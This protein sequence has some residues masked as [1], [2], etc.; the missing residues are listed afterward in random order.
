MDIASHQSQSDS[1]LY[2]GTIQVYYYVW[3]LTSCF[4]FL[5]I[6]RCRVIYF[7]HRASEFYFWFFPKLYYA[8]AET[9]P[10]KEKAPQSMQGFQLVSFRCINIQLYMPR[11]WYR[12]QG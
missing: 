1:A 7:T 5:L 3:L 11:N 10:G 6:N 8:F 4:Y 2:C 9:T 12:P